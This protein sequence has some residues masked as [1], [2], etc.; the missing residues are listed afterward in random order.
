MKVGLVFSGGGSRGFAHL[1][2][3]KALKELQIPVHELAGTSAGAIAGAFHGYG[4]SPEETFEI[5]SKTGFLKSVR[6]AWAWTGLLSLDGFKAVL[7]KYL[8]ENDFSALKIPLVIAATEIRKGRIV[9]FDSGE[10]VPAIIASS[11]IPT[12]FNPVLKDGQLFVDGGL[13]DNFPVGPLVGKCDIIIGSHCNPIAED[14]DARNVKEVT[15]RSLNLAIN[16]ASQ[17]SKSFCNLVI[18]PPGLGKFTTFDLGRGK[19]IFELGYTYT[20]S[21]AKQIETVFNDFE[22]I[23]S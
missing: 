7:F 21:I 23:G 12:L 16:A 20:I 4:Y 13:M 5:I 14:F 17:H 2:V 19:E 11:T 1:G 3:I 9:Y 6:P 10:L 15:E 18:E 22:K 8:P